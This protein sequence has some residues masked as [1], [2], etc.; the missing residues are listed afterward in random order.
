MEPLS[1]DPGHYPGGRGIPI[2]VC[3]IV[4]YKR[5]VRTTPSPVA[6]LRCLTLGSDSHFSTCASYC[7]DT[8][9]SVPSAAV[10]TKHPH[11]RRFIRY[12]QTFGDATRHRSTTDFYEI[13]NVF[14]WR[15]SGGDGSRTRVQTTTN[16]K[17]SYT[18]GS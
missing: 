2:C 8:I 1:S 3:A 11:M 12:L 6:V 17:T 13:G 14:N 7:A 5:W 9:S 15:K 4:S 10:K 18:I 16:T